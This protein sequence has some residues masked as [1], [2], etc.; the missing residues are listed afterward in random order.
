MYKFFAAILFVPAG[1]CV[2]CGNVYA[3]QS[4]PDASHIM[5][6][7]AGAWVICSVLAFFKE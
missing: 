4:E 7:L 3:A 1:F 2:Y 6:G 5:Y